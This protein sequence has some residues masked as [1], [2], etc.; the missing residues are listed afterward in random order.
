MKIE[1]LAAAALLVVACG[2]GCSSGPEPGAPQPGR[3]SPGTAQLSIDGADTGQIEAVECTQARH[4]TA[5][6]IGAENP[7]AAATIS[8]L[9]GLTVDWVRL[10]D[11]NSFTGSYNAGLG[12]EAHVVLAG[13][14]YQISGTAR[15]FNMDNPSQP[16]TAEFAIEVSC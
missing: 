2:A 4:T 9:D 11:A 15:G 5:I 12:G 6:T 14:A 10:R 1:C 7:V 13:S 3:M 16:T 8:K